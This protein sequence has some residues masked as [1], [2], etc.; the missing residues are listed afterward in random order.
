MKEDAAA[1]SGFPPSA[2]ASDNEGD[3]ENRD[4]AADEEEK[5]DDPAPEESKEAKVASQARNENPEEKIF[6]KMIKV[7]PKIK[8]KQIRNKIIEE[9]G[10]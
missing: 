10:V 6:D 4:A 8:L 5:A 1:D 9:L 7:P 3:D 2:Q